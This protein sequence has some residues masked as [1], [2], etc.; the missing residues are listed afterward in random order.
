M[1]A[2][3]LLVLTAVTAAVFG[4]GA[5][6]LVR[7]EG[8]TVVAV[9]AMPLYVRSPGNPPKVVGSMRPGK[10]LQVLGCDDTKSDIELH[11]SYQGQLAV[12]GEEFGKFRIHRQHIYPWQ[13]GAVTTCRGF[14][15]ASTVDA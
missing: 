14:Y 7:P 6:W 10:R 9:E 5:V 2:R 3:R 15:E 13:E 8:I 1:R 12:L 4:I 11:V